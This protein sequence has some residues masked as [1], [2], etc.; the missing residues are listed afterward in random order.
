MDLWEESER[1]SKS[2]F[3]SRDFRGKP[4]DIQYVLDFVRNVGGVSTLQ[5]LGGIYFKDDE[6]CMKAHLLLSLANNPQVS[7][8]EGGIRWKV[9]KREH[10]T[11]VTAFSSV[12]GEAVSETLRLSDALRAYQRNT[13]WKTHPEYML[14]IRTATLLTRLWASRLLAGL[15]T[16]DELCDIKGNTFK[17]STKQSTK[18][19]EVESQ[20]YNLVNQILNK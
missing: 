6:P 10:D 8:F 11:V 13:T 17:E 12:K 14:K 20:D 9:D 1:L 15:P 18:K 4:E 16:D 7:P 5:A 2:R 3:I 19:T